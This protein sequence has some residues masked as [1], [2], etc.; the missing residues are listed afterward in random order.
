MPKRDRLAR[1]LFQVVKLRDSVGLSVLCDMMVLYRQT[2]EVEYRLGLEQDKCSSC[3][4]SPS[5]DSAASSSIDEG[6]SRPMSTPLLSL[7]SDTLIDPA[8]LKQSRSPPDFRDVE[9]IATVTHNPNETDCAIWS[10]T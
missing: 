3:R 4:S 2:S 10:A 7:S 8:I 6:K 5:S 9:V 1:D